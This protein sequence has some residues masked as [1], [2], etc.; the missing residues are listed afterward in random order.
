M[1]ICFSAPFRDF[2]LDDF[3]YLDGVRGWKPLRL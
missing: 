3:A 2:S 1:E